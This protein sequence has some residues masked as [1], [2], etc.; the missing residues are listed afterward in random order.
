MFVYLEVAFKAGEN[1]INATKINRVECPLFLLSIVALPKKRRQESPTPE[2]RSTQR[3]RTRE[4]R[5]IFLLIL[6]LDTKE[7]RHTHTK[8]QLDHL[9]CRRLTER[10]DDMNA[11]PWPVIVHTCSFKKQNLVCRRKELFFA[12]E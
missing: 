5:K 8:R 11:Y 12:F 9:R 6:G 10:W 2:N 3:K 4:E 7:L 1:P